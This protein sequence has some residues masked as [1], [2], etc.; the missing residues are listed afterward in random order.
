MLFNYKVVGQNGSEESGS[1]E[2][3]NL[4]VAV[5]SLQRRGYIVSSIEPAEGG[6]VMKMLNSMFESV[7]TKELV[8]LSNQI[9]I[10]F[11]SHVSV[12]RIFRLLAESSENPVL[13]KTLSEVSDD[14]QGGESLSS[15]M[16]KHD[17]IFSEF[18]VNMVKAG[19]ESGKL[20]E[21]FAY[22]ATYMER[23]YEIVTK[24][25]N[26]LVYPAFVVA[27]FISVM[28]LM[29]VF[30]IPN[31]SKMLIDAGSP[32]P[33]YTQVVIGLS[34]FLINYGLFLLIFL[35]IAGVLIW[36]V[37]LPGGSWSSVKL[38]LPLFGTLFTKTYLSRISD[39]LETLLASG[40]PMLRSIEITSKVVGDETY[41]AIM[42]DVSEK[43][44]SGT[45]LSEAFSAYPEQI[46]N[47]M[48][49]MVRVGEETGELSII[50]KTLA[51]FYKREVDAS[52]DTLVGLIE[53]IMIVSLAVG[54]GFLLASVLIPIYNVTSTIT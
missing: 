38:K 19:E 34:N 41:S 35:A 16:A 43:V 52:I 15:A 24:T 4:D 45:S 50:L 2:A 29:L 14:I 23:S 11:S 25:K 28:T 53:P 37:G 1:I 21:T 22:L 48:I 30:V 40:V 10:L 49:Q 39:N 5:S 54:V 7:K 51:T 6:S 9:S 18:F 32:I 3:V 36:K 26:A 31:L 20:S 12:L 46:P 8:M 33:A 27:T 47:I 13:R 42:T 17:S 44:K